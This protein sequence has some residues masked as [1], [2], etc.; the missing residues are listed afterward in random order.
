MVGDVDAV[1]RIVAQRREITRANALD[2]KIEVATEII[3]TRKARAPDEVFDRCCLAGPQIREHA[4][5]PPA[6]GNQ[7]LQ[8]RPCEA[9]WTRWPHIA[10]DRLVLRAKR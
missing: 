1:V 4:L 9:W 2:E 5:Q 3:D 10:P 7:L 6:H 8:Q